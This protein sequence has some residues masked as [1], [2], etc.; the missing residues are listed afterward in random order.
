MMQIIYNF[1]LYLTT[2][3]TVLLGLFGFL[4]GCMCAIGSFPD[5][6]EEQE[7]IKTKKDYYAWL[8]NSTM[9]VILL[10]FTTTMCGILSGFIFGISFPLS[11]II[12]IYMIY[13]P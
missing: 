3:S 1:Y 10:I 5:I 6:F 11:L 8:F 4:F 2:F 9:H 13:F 12:P 7:E